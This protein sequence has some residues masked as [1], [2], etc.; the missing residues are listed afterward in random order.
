MCS[1]IN[2]QYLIRTV[3]ILVLCLVFPFQSYS[4]DINIDRVVAFGG[5]LT[6]TGNAFVLLSNP[7]A[8]DFDDDCELGTPANVPPYDALDDLFIPDGT[9]ARGG[10]HVTNGHTWIEQL[11]SGEGLS[12]NARPA[13]R[14]PGTKASNYSAGGARAN[15]YPCRYNLS[16]Q[17]AAYLDD[18]PLTSEDVLVVIE[19][20]GNDVRDAFAG[21]PADPTFTILVALASIENAIR[22]LNGQ[23]VDKFLLLNVPGIGYSPAV[24]ILDALDPDND[25]VVIGNALSSAFNDGLALM[26][27]TLK[28]ELGIDLRTLDLYGLL[29][30]IIEDPGSFGITNT[31]D[32]CVRPNIPPFVCE[33]PDTYLFWDGIHP[34]KAVHSIIAQRA[35]DVLTANQP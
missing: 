31:T 34:T 6:D 35:I 2:H 16:N 28:L 26:Q 13:L 10:H 4:Q 25:L 24:R 1:I 17:L 29:E 8:F 23:G 27:F 5:S 9:Y 14:N 20:G 18:F 19:L 12:G 30:E 11:A 21:L 7:S 32:A 22:T 15:D 33:S 3:S